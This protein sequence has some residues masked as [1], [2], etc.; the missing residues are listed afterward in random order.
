MR[1]KGAVTAAGAMMAAA[2]LT[3]GLMPGTA[4][5]SP[6]PVKYVNLGDSYSAGSGVMPPS[7]DTS[8]GCLQ[9]SSNY[10][11]LVARA[12]GFDLTDVSC[13]GAATEDF[14]GS[15]QAGVGPQLDALDDTVDLV[16]FSIGGNDESVFANTIVNCVLAGV[17]S[18]MRGS[19]CE[20]RHATSVSKTLQTVTYPNLVKTMKAVRAKAPNARVAALNYPWITPDRDAPCNGMPI[21]AGDGKFTHK[22]QAEL[23]EVIARAAKQTGVTLVDVATPSVGHDACKAAGVRWIEP[24]L[25]TVQV[26]PV[27][28]NALGE[29]R[30]AEVTAKAL[31]LKQ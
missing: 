25:T 10:A 2:A 24:I 7:M 27:H 1:F 26:V 29:R 8:L 15:Q 21:S 13:G 5:A 28:P 20:D 14:F 12:N 30:M 22:V 3:V 23:N 16:T 4:Q 17:G 6:E 11:K 31:G 19:P 18:G 9:S